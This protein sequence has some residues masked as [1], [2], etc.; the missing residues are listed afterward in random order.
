MKNSITIGKVKGI[1]IEINISWLVV[2]GLVT[3]TLAMS[4]FPANYPEWSSFARWS[5]A[6]IMAI[7]L[8]GS[9][10]LHELSHSVVSIGLG[11]DVKKI[12]LFIF[13]G[14]AQIER[15]PDD[16]VK[17][18]KIAIAG[19][20]MSLAI[21]IT[22]LVASRLLSLVEAPEFVTVPITYIANVN[23]I[24]AFFNM[25]PAF[26]LDGGRVLRA[27][28]WKAKGDIEVAT[29]IAS[30]A[31]G[32][33]G[34][35]IIFLGIF[36]A[37][38]GNIVNGIWFVFIGW[39]INQASQSS[40]Q[41]LI[42]NDIFGK[43]KVRKFMSENPVTVNSSISIKDMVEDYIYKYKYSSFPVKSRDR[44]IG[45]VNIERIKSTQRD[46]WEYTDVEAV[47]EKLN[48]S[49]VVSP[50]DSVAEAMNK[51]FRNEIGRVLVMDG[52]TLVGIVSRTDI[53]NHIRIY[54][55]LH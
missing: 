5:L 9:V 46:S 4:F 41:N 26:P 25:I 54:N 29:R 24:L 40:Y 39:F 35:L 50:E 42:V 31:G 32:V 22:T 13:G 47:T 45:I 52:D 20:M 12:T 7:A 1:D 51:I 30:A 38:T 8:F 49:L 6:A 28:I 17:E 33:F 37:L 14:V 53:L 36:L 19:P 23:L 34:Y 44:V 16:P 2:F 55:Q 43:I 15:E 48:E 18:L 11:I 27:A 10:L 21:A 3:F